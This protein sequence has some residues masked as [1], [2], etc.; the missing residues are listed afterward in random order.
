MEQQLNQLVSSI[1]LRDSRSSSLVAGNVR[2]AQGSMFLPHTLGYLVVMLIS[3]ADAMSMRRRRQQSQTTKSDAQT[4][5]VEH[6]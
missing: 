4:A 1:A 6:L 5:N 2:L 3:A